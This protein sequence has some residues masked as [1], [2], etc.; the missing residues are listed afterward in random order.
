MPEL[1][2]AETIAADLR[3][4]IEGARVRAVSVFRPDI[5]AGTDPARLGR[6]LRGR[7]LT[8]IG[9]R[10][11][12]VVFELDDGGRVLVNLGMTG[13]LI[14]SDAPN[15]RQMNHVAARFALDGGRDL[16]FDDT[17]RFG[18]IEVLEPSAWSVRDAALG[19]EPLSEG[20]TPD[21]FWKLVRRSR[22]PI[23]NRLLD[24][25][26][27]A[28]VGNIYANEA[29]FL[30]RVRPRRGARTL[31]RREA[32]AL[33]IGL[34]DVLRRAVEARGT[35]LRDYLGGGGQIGGFQPRLKVYGREGEPC[36]TCSTPIKR[37]VLTNR[38]AFYCPRCQR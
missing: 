27:V 28:G 23:R 7:R 25:R 22:T 21:A 20:F 31:R 1:P 16:L 30:A 2:E 35:T 26:F 3:E 32:D 9:R 18:R 17:R 4:R 37:V 6:R 19:L 38:S 15:A 5:L 34:R 11:K 8:R 29:L 13:R 12:N 36:P 10:G 14:T 24:Q 33:R